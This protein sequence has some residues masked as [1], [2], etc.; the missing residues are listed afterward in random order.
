MDGDEQLGL[1][2]RLSHAAEPTMGS[3]RLPLDDVLTLTQSRVHHGLRAL[4]GRR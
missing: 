2:L 4:S 1:V 3:L